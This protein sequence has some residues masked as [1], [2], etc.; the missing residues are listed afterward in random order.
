M[1]FASLA[2][3]LASGSPG[4]YPDQYRQR[5]PDQF[6]GEFHVA[7]ASVAEIEALGHSIADRGLAAEIWQAHQ[8]GE[9]FS[10]GQGQVLAPS[11]LAEKKVEVKV[12]EVFAQLQEDARK[13]KMVTTT[14][15]LYTHSTR[16]A[17][18]VLRALDI[19]LGQTAT[20]RLLDY[21]QSCFGQVLKGESVSLADL[22]IVSRLAFDEQARGLPPLKVNLNVPINLVFRAALGEYAKRLYY[23]ES[24]GEDL[25]QEVLAQSRRLKALQEA[26]ENGDGWAYETL[27]AQDTL[28]FY[29][30]P[31]EGT[32]A[33][34]Y[35]HLPPK[36]QNPND[37][38]GDLTNEVVK[39]RAKGTNTLENQRLTVTKKATVR[40]KDLKL[41]STSQSQAQQGQVTQTAPAPMQI[42][43]G[44]SP[45]ASTPQTPVPSPAP[46][47][48]LAATETSHQEGVTVTGFETVEHT[49][50]KHLTTG[51]LL[52][53]NT[54]RER[55]GKK[56]T[57]TTTEHH[58]P[59]SYQGNMSYTE[60]APHH[61]HQGTTY[62]NTH[63]RFQGGEIVA[64]TVIDFETVRS[65][66]P[67]RG[68][69]GKKATIR[70]EVQTR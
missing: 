44:R 58:L 37:Q 67:K 69:W 53:R 31:G 9:V 4:N 42:T 65:E 18:R 51:P 62:A 38:A 54:T 66:E 63:N 7:G 49:A 35:L 11:L 28:S 20:V 15:A 56:R 68:R 33:K 48:K 43:G 57:Q 41:V 22:P 32:L 59:T 3:D 5:R 17:A 26:E 24:G 61:L 50:G 19:D 60:T 23:G 47:L 45:K 52:M 1:T 34:V 8:G 46:V 36:V 39:L 64:T 12:E 14:L 55:E 25:L 2:Y 21:L 30:M 40:G 29:A 13:L 70:E 27:A 10:K 6:Y 16:Q